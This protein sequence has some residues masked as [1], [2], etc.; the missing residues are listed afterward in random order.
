MLLHFYEK[1]SLLDLTFVNSFLNSRASE[2]HTNN[3]GNDN[4]RRGY[5]LAKLF[6]SPYLA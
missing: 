1:I 6:K 2:N 3:G 4:Q 5:L